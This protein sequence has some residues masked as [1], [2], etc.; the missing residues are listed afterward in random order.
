MPGRS[1]PFVVALVELEEGA[2]GE[3]SDGGSIRM[4]GELR[5]VDPADVR[6][7]APVEVTYLD[8][9]PGDEE[10]GGQPW[11]LYAWTPPRQETA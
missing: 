1:L 6:I 9:P 11:T 7:G 5:G 2:G 8:F 10:T 3:R 4:L